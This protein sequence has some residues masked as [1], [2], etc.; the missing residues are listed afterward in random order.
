MAVSIMLT[1]CG[2]SAGLSNSDKRAD[3]TPPPPPA[4][5][6]FKG[7]LPQIT[8]GKNDIKQSLINFANEHI[9]KTIFVVA[10]IVVGSVFVVKFN[11]RNSNPLNPNEQPKILK[12][13]PKLLPYVSFNPFVVDLPKKVSGYDYEDYPFNT[14]DDNTLLYAYRS[15]DTFLDWRTP[16]KNELAKRSYD[17]ST[18]K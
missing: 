3:K 15:A 11:K 9:K 17:V 1:S 2:K 13:L 6:A 18:L 12:P 8:N 5:S 14:V 16:I 10:V 7:N 4:T